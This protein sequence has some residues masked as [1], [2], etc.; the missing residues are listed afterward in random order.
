MKH[1]TLKL[2]I[3]NLHDILRQIWIVKIGV[4]KYMKILT[5]KAGGLAGHDLQYP[6][7]DFGKLNLV[8]GNS[9]AGK[10]MLLNTIFNCASMAVRKNTIFLGSWDIILEHKNEKYRWIVETFNDQDDNKTKIALEQLIKYRDDDEVLII[11]RT[12]D[13]FKFNDNV[14]PKLSHSETSIALLQ[15]EDTINPIHEAMGLV[16]RRNFSGSVLKDAVTFSNL[17]PQIFKKIK[18][19]KKIKDLFHSDLN[20]N[21]KLYV[22]SEVFNDRYDSVCKEFQSIF[23]FVSKVDLRNASEFGIHYPELVPIFA[24]QEKFSDKWFPLSKFS[25]GMLKVLLVLCDI[26]ILPDEGCVYL[27]DEFE[28]SLG[29]NAINFFPPI[30]Y[31]SAANNQFIITSHHPYIISRIPVKDWI[32]LHRRGGN[33]E[34]QQGIELEGKYGKSRQEAFV[35]LTNDPFYI[36]GVR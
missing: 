15:D 9:G 35:Q 21:C 36:E 30:Y 29:I 17:P 25:S 19:S 31:D 33:V 18:S 10:T 5:Y 7:I 32:V 8:V 34:V 1:L 6:I 26:F 11:D 23:P 27:I 4:L 20:L 2:R 3:K 22:L 12:L 24:L 13:S 28:N 14:L 16:M